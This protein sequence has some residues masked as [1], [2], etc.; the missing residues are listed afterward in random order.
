ML[1][2]DIMHQANTARI[3]DPLPRQMSSSYVNMVSLHS[4]PKNE[5]KNKKEKEKKDLFLCLSLPYDLGQFHT[6]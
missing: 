5:K 2:A 4:T 6:K 3:S 1:K